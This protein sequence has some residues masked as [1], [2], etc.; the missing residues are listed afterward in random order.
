MK[1]IHEYAIDPEIITDWRSLRDLSD[2]VGVSKGRIIARMPKSWMR[3]LYDR[4]ATHTAK[5]AKFE[6]ALRRLERAVLPTGRPAKLQGHTW[7][8]L[9]IS[10]HLRC[11]FRAIISDTDHVVDGM[12][13]PD[14]LSEDH[15][16]WEAA[17]ELPIPRD[18]DKWVVAT[19]LL[20][21]ACSELILIDPHFKPEER[22][23]Q[24]SLKALCQAVSHKNPRNPKVEYHVKKDSFRTEQDFEARCRSELPDWI[25]SGVKVEFVI[26]SCR[27]GGQDFHA[28]YLMTN[29]GGIRFEQG[30][31]EK[32]T[33]S[34]DTDVSLLDDE[35]YQ[36]RKADF[37]QES[38][39]C[40]FEK[41]H[42][43]EIMGR[44]TMSEHHS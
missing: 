18:S 13:K 16:Q 22:R 1:L 3:D 41:C 10:E 21:S 23:Y 40:A 43:F 17:R 42:A 8:N 36:R 12:V 44:R 14:E 37:T 5:D 25:A 4:F 27:S 38:D 2:K 26:W 20:L 29:H 11:P 30:L 19:E 35:L 15:P 9:A 28:R 32:R 34:T 7:L 31:D 6:L 33:A 39:K 24:R